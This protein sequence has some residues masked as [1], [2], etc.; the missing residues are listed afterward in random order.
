MGLERQQHDVLHAGVGHFLRALDV[1]RVAFGAVFLDQFQAIGLDRG[2]V[3]AA[4]DAGDL[5]AGEGEAGAEEAADGTGAD[6]GDFHVMCPIV[7]GARRL[8]AAAACS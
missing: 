6:D 7:P 4:G 2:E 8:R 1:R 5:L 3:G